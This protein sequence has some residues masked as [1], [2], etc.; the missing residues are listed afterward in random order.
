MREF[1]GNEG[2]IYTKEKYK[3]SWEWNGKEKRKEE[4]EST[5]QEEG[6]LKWKDK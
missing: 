2:R 5:S 3:G 1:K 4:R 6:T